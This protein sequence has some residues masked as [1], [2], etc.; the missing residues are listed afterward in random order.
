MFNK[1]IKSNLTKKN[2]NMLTNEL[3]YFKAHQKELVKKYNKKFIVI[4]GDQVVG[5]YDTIDKAYTE[6]SK[7]HELGTFF[8]QQCLPGKEAYSQSF[9]SRVIFA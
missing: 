7:K 4:I 6:S 9:N 3:I 5:S 1:S 2:N 8:I